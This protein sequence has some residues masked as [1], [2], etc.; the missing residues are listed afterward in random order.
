M[1]GIGFIRLTTALAVTAAAFAATGSP[2]AAAARPRAL[3]YTPRTLA[4]MAPKGGL[5]HQM[6]ALLPGTAAPSLA[7]LS[8]FSDPATVTVNDVSYRMGLSVDN[9]PAAFD[10]PPQLAVGLDRVISAGGMLTG[11]Q[12]HVYGYAPIGGMSFTANAALTR[13][14]VRTGTSIDPSA[15]HMRFHA[16]EPVAQSPCTLVGGGH[17][18]FQVATGALSASTFKVAT[19]RRP[20]SGR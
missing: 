4:M 6:A 10:Q 7:S 13:A 1:R 19:G 18:V 2:A 8:L 17:G 20:S 15:I 11:E 9:L 12:E 5:L 16:T 3:M 14:T